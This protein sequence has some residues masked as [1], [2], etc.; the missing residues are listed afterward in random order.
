MPADTCAPPSALERIAAI[1]R[2]LQT[3]RPALF[4][5]FDGTLAPIVADPE[6]AA[7]DLPTRQ[8]VQ[9]IAALC[10]TAVI[11]G[12]DLDDVRRRVGIDGIVYAGSHGFD[13]AG[14]GWRSQQGVDALP[15]L[16]AAEQRLRRAL[17]GVPGA[18]LDRKRFSLAV[19]YRQVAAAD[20]A[21]LERAVD[22][23]LAAQPG[24]RKGHGKKVFELQPDIDWDKGAA[25]RWLLRELSLDRADVLPIHVGDDV[26]DEDAFRAL[27][28]DGL[29]I[30]VF[31]A[32]RPTAAT[33]RL[34]DPGEVRLFLQALTAH[35]QA[36]A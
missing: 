26:T 34:R 6:Q 33:Y 28:D 21:L 27:R 16:D 10:P 13:I 4:L 11:S 36:A 15:L 5:D 3:Q 29:G 31:D 23:A 35:L 1:R 24:L 12:R 30:V 19:H 8:G 18:L 14:P 9:A 32:P 2:R 25:L 20:V 17:A 7:I 22:A